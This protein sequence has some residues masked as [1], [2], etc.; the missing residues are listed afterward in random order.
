MLATIL[1]QKK[2]TFN[3]LNQIRYLIQ[4]NIYLVT[5]VF[6]SMLFTLDIEQAD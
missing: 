6:K 4:L 1:R 5:S 2:I 3:V